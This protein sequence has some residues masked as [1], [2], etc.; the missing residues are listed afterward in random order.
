M[1][2]LIFVFV[3]LGLS[4]AQISEYGQCGGECTLFT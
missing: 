1:F 2:E 4:C 3:F